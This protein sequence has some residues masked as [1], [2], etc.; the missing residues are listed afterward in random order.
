MQ[1]IDFVTQNYLYIPQC[2]QTQAY[3]PGVDP[4]WVAMLMVVYVITYCY[5]RIQDGNR[6][7]I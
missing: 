7:G 4:T 5:W 3:N 1:S 6:F 2:Q